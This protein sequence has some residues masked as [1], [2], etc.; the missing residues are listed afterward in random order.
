MD[1]IPPIF[2][3]TVIIGAKESY[4]SNQNT[5]NYLR[6]MQINHKI[7]Q[8]PGKM[9]KIVFFLHLPMNKNFQSKMIKITCFIL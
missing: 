4:L 7:L 8:V 2:F 6:G 1:G 5:E 3:R 9:N